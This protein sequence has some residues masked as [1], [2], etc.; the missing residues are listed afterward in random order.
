MFSRIATT[1]FA[2]VLAFG[3]HSHAIAQAPAT[4]TAKPKSVG[5]V[6]KAAAKININT[7]SVEK[8]QDLPGIGPARAAEIVKARP[9]KS[10]DDLKKINGISDDVYKGI[11][12]LISLGSTTTKKAVTKEAASK[13][14]TKKEAES[15]T[16]VKS[17]MTKEAATKAETKTATKSSTPSAAGKIDINKA[18]VK[19]LQE[20]P[21]IGP[22]RAAEIVKA[23][24][25]KKLDDLKELKGISEEVFKGLAP[26]VTL[27]S[28]EPAPAPA[29]TAKKAVTAKKEEMKKPA[30]E[31]KPAATASKEAPH[32]DEAQHISKKKT[33]LADGRKIN[34]NTA[35]V[36]ELM[37]LPGI[38]PVRSAAIVKARPFEK[39][40]DVMK[41]DGIKDGIFGHIKD[42][43][44][45]K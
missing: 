5:P 2:L 35:S 16:A 22:A 1:T 45:V 30:T 4:T 34:L 28:S 11:Q 38:G 41:A 40:E 6:K 21:G 44:S 18:T 29:T 37:E 13:V 33:A 42:H 25:I 27:G 10:L 8:L 24:P 3:F 12:P 32:E 39:I 23:R 19:E 43:I 9:F 20:L 31:T 15:K 7:A 17:P 26:L 14:A 36:E